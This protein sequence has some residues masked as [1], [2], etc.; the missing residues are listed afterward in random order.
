MIETLK[1][2]IKTLLCWFIAPAIIELVSNSIT[3]NKVH[4]LLF[5]LLL[6][7][8][9]ILIIIS[10]TFNC[11]GETK[12]LN[13]STSI[14]YLSLSATLIILYFFTEPPEDASLVFSLFLFTT[15]VI[16]LNELIEHIIKLV[17]KLISN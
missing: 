4:A 10:F 3:L 13:K 7:P 5:L 12:N 8:M 2:I 16:L 17:V 11:I 6:V 15:I 9:L 1:L 14:I